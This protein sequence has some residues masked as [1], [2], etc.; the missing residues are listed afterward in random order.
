MLDAVGEAARGDLVAVALAEPGAAHG[1]L[2]PAAT[3]SRRSSSAAA[4]WQT[5]YTNVS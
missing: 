4:S 2:V 3:G 1:H 5:R